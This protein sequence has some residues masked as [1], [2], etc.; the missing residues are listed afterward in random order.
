[1]ENNKWPELCEQL[2]SWVDDAQQER[3]LSGEELVLLLIEKIGGQ[4]MYLPRATAFKAY[5]RD[6]LIYAEFTGDNHKALC[7]KYD[8]SEPRIYQIIQ[9]Q[10]TL[11]RRKQQTQLELA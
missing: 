1:M 8:L 4:F 5:V 6:R 9:E 3:K 10:R 2:I 11:R 7:L